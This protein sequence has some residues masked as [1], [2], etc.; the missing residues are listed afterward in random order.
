MS[1]NSNGNGSSNDRFRDLPRY[2]GYDLSSREV[3]DLARDPDSLSILYTGRSRTDM[4][5]ALPVSAWASLVNGI[6]IVGVSPF[7]LQERDI[8]V[9]VR[10]QPSYILA[11][12]LF[13]KPELYVV[14]FNEHWR[15]TITRILQ[16]TETEEAS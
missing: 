6:R 4:A 10:E 1:K 7:K 14:P 8:L 12:T 15:T 16:Q 11:I 9:M 5:L 3:M 13:G 2:R